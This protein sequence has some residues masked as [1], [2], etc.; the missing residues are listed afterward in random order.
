MCWMNG[1]VSMTSQ[2]SPG[3]AKVRLHRRR[4]EP[5]TAD[6][7]GDLLR[8]AVEIHDRQVRRSE[9]WTYLVPIWVALIAGAVG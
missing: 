6:F 9:R 1:P 7:V 8:S 5:L 4:R 2:L 3:F